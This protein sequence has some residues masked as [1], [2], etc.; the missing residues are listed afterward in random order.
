MSVLW[1]AQSCPQLHLPTWWKVWQ[2]QSTTSHWWLG[3]ESWSVPLWPQVQ[4]A[5]GGR[6]ENCAHKQLV[7]RNF[8]FMPCPGRCES[9]SC[10]QKQRVVKV[11]RMQGPTGLALGPQPRSPWQLA[12]SQ[13]EQR[14]SAKVGR[15]L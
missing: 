7:H 8:H 5:P 14:Q 12:T 6:Y 15:A 1:Q 11:A 2:S 9:R 13:A 3:M 10:P 4:S